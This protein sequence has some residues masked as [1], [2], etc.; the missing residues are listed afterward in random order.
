MFATT[1]AEEMGARIAL[2]VTMVRY[3]PTPI[4]DSGSTPILADS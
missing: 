3:L 4:P 2:W 1:Q